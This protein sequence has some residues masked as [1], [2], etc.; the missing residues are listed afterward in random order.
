MKDELPNNSFGQLP[1]EIS[2][3]IFSYLSLRQLIPLF[4][5][6]KGVAQL[7]KAKRVFFIKMF[8]C[9]VMEKIGIEYRNGDNTFHTQYFRKELRRA[10]HA[11]LYARAK[12]LPYFGKNYR[13]FSNSFGR[14]A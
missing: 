1:R 10:S 8:N 7:A 4:R 9:K 2:E 12:L 6:S 5:V 14:K 3:E 11:I 13:N